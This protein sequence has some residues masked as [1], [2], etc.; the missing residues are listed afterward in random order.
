MSQQIEIYQAATLSDICRELS[1][2]KGLGKNSRPDTKYLIDTLNVEEHRENLKKKGFD[3]ENKKEKQKV[4]Y[5]AL[6]YIYEDVFNCH[7]APK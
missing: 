6:K 3:P 2:M 1:I 4:P 5:S 7:L